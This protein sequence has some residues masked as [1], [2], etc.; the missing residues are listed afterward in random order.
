[1]KNQPD[2]RR[3]NPRYS[4][5]FSIHGDRTAL[6]F[7]R[8]FRTGIG[9]AV[10]L[11]FTPGI[12]TKCAAAEPTV[13]IQAIDSTAAEPGTN[14]GAF[15][16]ARTG[17]TGSPLTVNYTVGGTASPGSDYTALSG[18]VTIPVGETYA[19]I[20]VTALSDILVESTETVIVTLSANAAYVIGASGSATVN[21]L[22]APTVW[23]GMQASPGEPSTLGRI[24]FVREYPPPPTPLTVHYTLSGSAKPG[25]DYVALSGSATIPANETVGTMDIVPIDDN[26][27]EGQEVVTVVIKPDAAYNIWMDTVSVG[28]A[29]DDVALVGIDFG[30]NV[31]EP[32]TAGRF[33]IRL[34]NPLEIPVTVQYSMSGSATPGVDYTAVSGSVQLTPDMWWTGGTIPVT[35]IDDL[36]VEGTETI[37]ATITPGANY[38]VHPSWYGNFTLLLEDNESTAPPLREFYVAPNG[39]DGNDGS[40]GSPFR[41]VRHALGQVRYGDTIYLRAGDYREE[42]FVGP[43]TV[44]GWSGWLPTLESSVGSWNRMV[45]IV[46]YNGEEAVIKGSEIV[47]GWTLDQVRDQTNIWRAPSPG[48]GRSQQVFVDGRLLGHVG[49]NAQLEIYPWTGSPAADNLPSLLQIVDSHGVSVVYQNTSHMTNW[50]FFEDTNTW[51]VYI[52]LPN[53]VDPNTHLVEVSTRIPFIIS[54]DYFRLSGIKFRHANTLPRTGGWPGVGLSAFSIVENCDVQWCDMGGLSVRD[55]SRIINCLIANNGMIGGGGVGTNILVSGS[56]FLTNHYLPWD[57][58]GEAA[59]SKNIGGP[60]YLDGCIWEGNEFAYNRGEGLWFDTM[61]VRDPYNNPVIIR[62]NFFHDNTADG[63][64]LE[65]M[66]GVRVHNNIS[67]RNKARAL[68]LSSATHCWV[69][70]NT[71]TSSNYSYVTLNIDGGLG[72]RVH[73]PPHDL[74][75][76][77]NIMSTVETNAAEGPQDGTEPQIVANTM[78][79]NCIG[80]ANINFDYNCYLILGERPDLDY[81]AMHNVDVAN[82]NYGPGCS[83]GG[84]PCIWWQKWDGYG[85]CSQGVPPDAW[86]FR[87]NWSG[88]QTFGNDPH[89]LFITDPAII[90]SF[91]INEAADDYRI[92][93]DSPAAHAGKNLYSFL[94]ADYRGRQRPATGN[95][96]IGAHEFIDTIRIVA[97]D[98]NAG[99]P[100]NTGTFT[101]TRES[102]D[103][104]VP[105]TVTYTV[106]GSATPGADYTALSG[107]VTFG[108]GVTSVPLQIT[109]VNDA[110]AEGNET[111]IVTLNP[112]AEIAVSANLGSATVTIV[113][114]EQLVTVAATDS[115]ASEPGSDTGTFTITRQGSTA[116]SLTVYFSISGTATWGTDYASIYGPVTIPAGQSSVNVTVQPSTDIT[117]ESTETVILTLTANAAYTIG[118]PNNATVN[119]LDAPV[120]WITGTANAEEPSTTGSFTITR[121]F[122]SASALTVFYTVSGTA[123]PGVD[124]TTLSGSA[125]IPANAVSVAVNVAPI[126]D[127]VAE[128]NEGITLTLQTGPNYNLYY[129]TASI[130]LI[131]NEQLVTVTATDAT[132]AEPGSNTGTF[133]ITRQGSTA[134]SLTVYFS[135]SGTATWGTDY[136]S[137]YSPVTIPAGQSSVNVTVQPSTDITAESTE[138]VILTLSANASYTIGS[139]NN[140]TVNLLD[141]PVV[142]ITGTANAEEPSTT[143]SFTITRNAAS[144]STLTVFY[145]VSGTA[146]PGA[147]YTTLSGSATIPANATSVAVNVAPIDDAV[148][149][150][151]EGITLTL[152]PGPNY[153]LYYNTASISLIDNEQLVTVTATD[154]TAAEPGSNTGTFTITR[155]GSTASSLT[156]YFS[157]SGT[158]TP[159]TDY[160]SLSSPVTIPA[161]QSS[162]NVTVQ[163]GT[164]ITAE[165]TETVILTLT[166]NAAYTIGSPNNAT[167]N[168]LDAPVVWIT[169]TANA[170]EPSTTGSF[171]ITRNA[172][173]ASALTVYFAVSGTATPGADY[174]AL[175]GSATIPA[176]ATS[177]T[178]SVVP[179]DDVLVEATEGVTL[180]LQPGSN[181]NLY[182]NVASISLLSNE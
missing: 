139:P 8:R 23:V 155:Q 39:N 92:S 48:A 66:T 36:A 12:T 169:G 76:S 94:Q 145:A 160:T 137:I 11:W 154:A 128:G 4:S 60:Q 64:M 43:L 138:T 5:R 45:N 71:L 47:S 174:A 177:V 164:D 93:A 134:S 54:Y 121:S 31:G 80:A 129:N 83:A 176:N 112:G 56:R 101:V 57:F 173:S 55:Q 79:G 29:D 181:Y 175:G 77:N 87:V 141:A 166:A 38:S 78:F 127:A 158:A 109:P 96:S 40:F 133:T 120:V 35:P 27:V 75:I 124:Y 156:V 81:L 140:A 98:A 110:V 86:I 34:A 49:W 85:L 22:N 21:I 142:W 2:I 115:T 136:A 152:Q 144:A 151:N 147:D 126:D 100:S 30:A 103:P 70:N 105:L 44:W 69:F 25:I 107:T 159:G 168:I 91:F 17:P 7:W 117:Q 74:W 149:E 73:L 180:T 13:T 150:G 20:Q 113:D 90:N 28:F 89:G 3:I 182:Y 32:G 114:D 178:V 167:V 161:G 132:A 1:M 171:T 16:V 165:S 104:N 9:L 95:F 99:E 37:T 46:N 97:T 10:L 88:W 52:G 111:V 61:T 59:G 163:P 51:T 42:I 24:A 148:A 146:T 62:T 50:S 162:V 170:A 172:S 15:A 19:T 157:I 153:N 53:G 119:L 18:S 106:S 41:T 108:S 65:V 72:G 116:S 58:R 82:A 26:A 33:L 63:L 135:I 130:S 118:S 14:T 67:V 125:T 143:G 102:L 131:D 84:P 122:T 179:F 6:L 68:Y 123:T